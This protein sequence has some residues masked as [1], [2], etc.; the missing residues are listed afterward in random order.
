M[1]EGFIVF[2][3]YM[4]ALLKVVAISLLLTA[5]FQVVSCLIFNINFLKTCEQWLINQKIKI[6]KYKK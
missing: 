1:V 6:I 2:V 3:I 5:I 4:L